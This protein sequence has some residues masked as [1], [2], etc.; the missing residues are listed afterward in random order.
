M[1]CSSLSAAPKI[2]ATPKPDTIVSISA[3]SI[4][5]QHTKLKLPNAPK[6]EKP[7]VTSKTYKITSTTEIDLNGEMT[8]AD[9][10]K[11]GMVVSVEFE[12]LSG[13]EVNKDIAGIA[14]RIAA[15]TDAQK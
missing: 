6:K 10:L 2:P 4:T 13:S 3:D 5:V 9:K 11:P 1:V 14:T 15:Q 7:E 12:S 8:K